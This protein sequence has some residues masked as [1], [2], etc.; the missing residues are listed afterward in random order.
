[1]ASER[2]IAANSRNAQKSTR[3]ENLGRQDEVKP[4]RVAPP[5]KLFWTLCSDGRWRTADQMARTQK[6]PPLAGPCAGRSPPHRS[7]L[8]RFCALGSLKVKVFV[9]QD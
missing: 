8:P 4:Q 2:Q 3:P 7:S 9:G 1:M 5:G 6:P